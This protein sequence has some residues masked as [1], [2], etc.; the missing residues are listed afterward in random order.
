MNQS[1]KFGCDPE[2]FLYDTTTN[3]HVP[4]VGLYPGTKDKPHKVAKSK[5]GLKIQEDGVTL[6]FNINPVTSVSHFS[7]AIRSARTEL[8]NLVSKTTPN[9]SMVYAPYVRFRDE[10]LQSEQANTLGCDPDMRAWDRGS[11]RKPPSIKELGNY[12]FAGGHIHVGYDVENCPVPAW[13]IVQFM[14][15]M[16]YLHEIRQGYD[17]QGERRKF[18][19]Q[20]GLFRIKPYGLE[21]RT[22]SNFWLHDPNHITSCLTAAS[23]VINNPETARGLWNSID[24][25]KDDIQH[26]VVTEKVSNSLY[27]L[28][29]SLWDALQENE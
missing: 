12:R 3:Y 21:Y 13:A 17:A 14:E 8:A 1:I 28:S 11:V 15:V 20:P 4:C 23:L 22:P 16:G 9:L 19:G 26:A 5:Y 25:A 29:N 18:Y 24:V 27:A 7:T 2:V 6:E 10:D